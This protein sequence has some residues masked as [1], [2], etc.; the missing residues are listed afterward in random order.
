MVDDGFFR[1]KRHA[2]AAEAATVLVGMRRYNGIL[3]RETEW[4]PERADAAF[5][6]FVFVDC[7]PTHLSISLLIVLIRKFRS[8]AATKKEEDLDRECHESRKARDELHE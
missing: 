8:I 2:M 3:F 4:A 7:N 1:A 5:A 6:A